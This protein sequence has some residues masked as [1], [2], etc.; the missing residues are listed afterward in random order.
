ML[1]CGFLAGRRS[2]WLC[3]PAADVGEAEKVRDTNQS[4]E[5]HRYEGGDEEV[6]RVHPQPLVDTGRADAAEKVQLH[7]L[8]DAQEHH[9]DRG[10]LDFGRE[11]EGGLSGAV[12]VVLQC[13]RLGQRHSPGSSV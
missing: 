13:D 6:V 8:E 5:D 11:L 2:L 9:E 3:H 7:E 10:E 1:L 4:C 12:S